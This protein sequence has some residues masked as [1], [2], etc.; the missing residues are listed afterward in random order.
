DLLFGDAGNDSLDG[1]IGADTLFGGT[2]NDTLNLAQGDSAEG[3]DGDDFF[4]LTD[5]AEAET[6]TITLSRTWG[7]FNV[8][9]WSLTVSKG[10][11]T[12][13]RY[14]AVDISPNTSF[15][16]DVNV[17]VGEAIDLT[18]VENNATY[19]WKKGTTVVST[20]KQFYKAS[21]VLADAGTNYTLKVTKAGCTATS[22]PF[23]ISVVN[24][25]STG[26]TVTG[27]T[28]D[29]G[30]DATITV[31]STQ[32]GVTYNVYKNDVYVTSGVGTGGNIVITIPAANLEVG[33]NL[34]VV[35]A[36]NGNCE[37]SLSST[38]TIVVRTPGFT[39]S[40]ISGNTTEAG[41][42][43]TFTVVLKTQPTADVTLPISSSD[44]TEGTVST[45]SLTFTS[46]NWNVAQTVTVTGV[47][48]YIVDGNI[49]YTINIGP[50]T[51]SDTY[52][53][54]IDPADINLLNID[55]DV[56]GVNV[57]P[58]S[59]LTTTEA[60]GTA[61]FTMRLTAQPAANVTITLTSSNTAEGTV[62]PTSVTFTSANWNTN[63]TITITGV[64]DQVDDG[65]VVYTIITSNTSSTDPVFNNIAV[66]DV[67]VTNTNN[68]VAGI[69]VN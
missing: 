18:A 46:A 28:V 19:E 49:S 45:A 27:S 39:I 3:G 56:A 14:F 48:D 60:G 64:D 29:P 52:Y 36:D 11:C 66:A 38:A 63:Q 51:S 16:G 21:A 5:L 54:G 37:I 34:F 65:D 31:N 6:N 53:N 22:A 44:L 68:D 7:N 33:N 12:S 2:G 20:A 40:A 26:L 55:N 1:G 17:C 30:H 42:T 69:V 59:G 47:D 23:T 43:A 58:T 57:S 61:T 8:G 15:T 10:G 67:T 9:Q 32:N 4:R 25:P 41:G 62:N 35:K 13:T 50:A 24:P